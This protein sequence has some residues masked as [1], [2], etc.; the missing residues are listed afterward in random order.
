MG[1]RCFDG[2]MD[3]RTLNSSYSCQYVL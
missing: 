3:L 1:T 2:W